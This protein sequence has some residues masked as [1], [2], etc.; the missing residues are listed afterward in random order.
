MVFAPISAAAHTSSVAGLLCVK[1]ALAGTP[2]PRD[3]PT[4]LSLWGGLFLTR[5]SSDFLTKC[6]DSDARGPETALP[7]WQFLGRLK[8]EEPAEE[9]V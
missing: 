4:A 1:W 9:C 2:R 8:G 7:F 6:R 5:R 3:Q